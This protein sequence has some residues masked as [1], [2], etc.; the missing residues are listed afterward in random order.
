MGDMVGV[1]IFADAATD[2][3]FDEDSVCLLILSF[4]TLVKRCDHTTV[5]LNFL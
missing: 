2:V 3:S 5:D 4:K 1:D